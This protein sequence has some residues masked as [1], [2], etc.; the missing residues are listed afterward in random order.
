MVI[1]D[2]YRLLEGFLN[3][4]SKNIIN[5]RMSES[6]FDGQILSEKLSKLNS[7]QQSIECILF[8]RRGLHV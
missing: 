7:S 5:S 6:A 8:G 2:L 1:L 4:R 3:V